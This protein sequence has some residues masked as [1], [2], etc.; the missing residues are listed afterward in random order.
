MILVRIFTEILIM[1]FWKII[2]IILLIPLSYVIGCIVYAKVTYFDPPIIEL[3]YSNNQTSKLEEDSF[4][5][6][7]WNIGYA[8]LGAESD[9]FYDGGKMMNPEEKMVHKYFDGIVNSLSDTSIDFILLQEVDSHSKRSY[10]LD[11]VSFLKAQAHKSNPF[12]HFAYNYKVNYIPQPWTEPM[13]KVNS[14]LLSLAKYEPYKVERHQLPGQFGFP[15]QLFFLR[16]C[17]LIQYFHLTNGKD[18]IFINIHNSAYDDS[19]KL[20]AEEMAYLKTIL[21]KEDANGNYIVCGGDWN[22]CPPDFAYN[23]LAAGKEGDYSQTN[24]KPLTEGGQWIY[25]PQIATNRKNDKAYDAKKTFTTVIDFFWVSKN[26]SAISC[27]GINQNF[28]F[29]DHQ[30]VVFKFKLNQ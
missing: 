30:P 7:I 15:K 17:L 14:G 10:Y 26:I 9:F 19:G 18:L 28:E 11:Q 2:G 1:N 4:S 12:S 13:G 20:K 29:S 5:A 25:D 21:D 22:Q 3:L 27:H 23:R 8:G 16:R 6:M 24:V